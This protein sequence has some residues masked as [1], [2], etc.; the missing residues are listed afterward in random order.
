[1]NSS[2]DPSPGYALEARPRRFPWLHLLLFLATCLST[3]SIGALL[4]AEFNGIPTETVIQEISER[5]WTILRGWPFAL[6]IMTFLFAHEMGHYLT[7]RYYGI[8]ATLPYFI[9]FP[10]LVGTMGAFI[11]IRS[12]IFDRRSLLDVGI[13]GPIAGFVIAVAALTISMGYGRF[14]EVEELN[15]SILLGEPL[16]FKVIAFATG[17]RPPAGMDVYMHPV[18]FAAWFGFLA[19]A[20][21]LLPAAQLDGGHVT[22]AIFLGRHRWIS[23]AVVATLV[24]LAIFYWAGWWVW[25]VLLLLLR[26]RHPPT[27]DDSIPLQRRHY[28]LGWI[29][30]AMLILCF[31]PAPFALEAPDQ[32]DEPAG[33]GVVSHPTAQPVPYRSTF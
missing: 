29:G 12:P 28:V 21:N 26:L 27:I 4:M 3:I 5:P 17:M 25:V 16:V 18:S 20:L 2:F 7:C 23:I 24:P 9:P 31:T 11:K 33:H 10:S 22:Y 13:A 1:M 30:L 32:L 8:D 19:T 15:N 6:T 14:V